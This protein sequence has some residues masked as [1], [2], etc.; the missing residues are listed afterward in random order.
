[1]IE[2]NKNIQSSI[3]IQIEDAVQND[4]LSGNLQPGQ[5]VP[6]V[7]EVAKHNGINPNTVQK[8]YAELIEKG[9]LFSVSGKGNYVTPEAGEIRNNEKNQILSD[10]RETAKRAKTAG[11]WMD[12]LFSVLDSA[13][14][15]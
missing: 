5:K 11:I 2:I 14:N 8:A 13:Y 6:S 7:R 9:I 4:I 10:L 3:Y 15:D 1:M 12:E